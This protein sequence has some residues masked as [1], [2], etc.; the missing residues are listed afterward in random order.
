MV[1]LRKL[2]STFS[3]GAT[4]NAIISVVTNVTKSLRRA[5][6]IWR[7]RRWTWGYFFGQ[8]NYL[9]RLRQC[10]SV[11]LIL[12]LFY[13][14]VVVVVVVEG[15]ATERGGVPRENDDHPKIKTSSL[16]LAST[17]A[18]GT[19]RNI[20]LST[21]FY[22]K[23]LNVFNNR[24]QVQGQFS[25]PTDVDTFDVFESIRCIAVAFT[26]I[27]LIFANIYSYLIFVYN[28]V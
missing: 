8:D 18:K 23:L 3:N 26:N 11:L 22:W 24:S 5:E 10:R 7:N 12:Y 27:C 25:N 2:K 6:L 17:N 16:G 20:H 15:K 21:M 9:F 14:R 1:Y 4:F 19:A 28:G 13:Q